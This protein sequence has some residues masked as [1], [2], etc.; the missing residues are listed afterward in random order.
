MD[1]PRTPIRSF[2]INATLTAVALGLLAWTVWSNR[3]Q[4]KGVLAR[5]PD[6]W[7]LAIGFAIYL[8]A[9]VLTFFRWFVLVRALGLPF[10]F[11]DAIRLGFIGNVFNL[12]I[13]GAVG[14]DVIKAAF[15]CR[16][17]ERKTQAVASMVIDRILGLIGLF[18]LAGIAGLGIWSESGAEVQRLILAAWLA[19]AAGIVGLAI[20]FTPAWYR[21][22]L[23][24]VA[25]R[26]RLETLL[27]ELVVMASAYRDRI[28]V[29][30]GM[31]TLASGIYA[32]Y[33][34]AFY[35]VS[36]SLFP[37]EAPTL[38]QHFLVVP[39]TLFTTAA[40]LPFGALGLTENVSKVLFDLVH[41]PGG[42]VAMMGYRV[43]MYAGGL[44]S[45]G[46]YFANAR[47]VRDL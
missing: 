39:L 16:E 20:L 2:V 9:L 37:T 13:P 15:L 5:R 38:A 47:Q 29:I 34:L 17:Q 11:A 19:V 45:A 14:G 1:R 32:L 6:P 3:I 30:I 22:L 46:V 27:M 25:G 42:A 23:K 35:C 41:F 43:L 26:G 24:L 8:A 18:V 21:P 33:V 10:R 40:P 31:L 36:L 44:V 28:G 4:I 12:V 7:P